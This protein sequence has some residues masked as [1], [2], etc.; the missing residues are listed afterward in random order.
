MGM[1]LRSLGSSHE[2]AGALASL[3]EDVKITST[4]G[5]TE[6][7]VA[8]R[9]IFYGTVFAS[10]IA[11]LCFLAILAAYKKKARQNQTT[12]LWPLPL[13]VR[14]DGTCECRR[15]LQ[16]AQTAVTPNDSTYA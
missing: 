7:Q 12:D 16:S 2:R 6:L 9:K 8:E 13:L 1:Y 10:A 5:L 4:A 14:P 11:V 15:P 3:E